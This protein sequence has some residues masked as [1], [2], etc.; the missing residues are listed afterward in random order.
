MIVQ[1]ITKDEAIAALRAAA[2]EEQPESEDAVCGH[3]GCTDHPAKGRMRIHSFRSFIGCDWDLD[4]AEAAVRAAQA[5]AWVD[6]ILDHNLAVR[7]QDGGTVRFDAKR[8]ADG[9]GGAS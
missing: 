5:V 1:E 7:E 9:S 3:P 8:P 4:R 2:W 6:D